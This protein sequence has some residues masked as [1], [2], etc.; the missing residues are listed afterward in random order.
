MPR[1]FIFSDVHAN[2]Y[3]LNRVWYYIRDE[4]CLSIDYAWCLG[5]VLGLGPWPADT[6]STIED[7]ISDTRFPNQSVWLAG[8]HDWALLRRGIGNIYQVGEGGV[9]DSWPPYADTAIV[10]H[11][12]ALESEQPQFLERLEHQ[13]LVA[14]PAPLE[15]VYLAHGIYT[16]SQNITD[17]IDAIWFYLTTRGLLEKHIY[18]PL[19]HQWVTAESQN[20]ALLNIC[21]HTHKQLLLR[22][23]LTAPETSDFD[24]GKTWEMIKITDDWVVMESGYLYHTNPGSIGFP[25]DQDCGQPSFAL[26]EWGD[27]QPRRLRLMRLPCEYYDTMEVRREL[28]AKNYPAQIGKNRLINCSD[29]GHR[30]A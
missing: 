5:D 15:G 7:I 2:K 30:K 25:S 9:R 11:L 13:M 16:E 29:Y 17:Q 26:L 1:A 19:H 21:G 3:A 20:R 4:L 24:G 23:P 6:I 18:R 10:K 8:N 27:N 28:D 14:T 12:A 22:R